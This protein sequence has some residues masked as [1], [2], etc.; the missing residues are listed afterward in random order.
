MRRAV[1]DAY[2]TRHPL[3]LQGKETTPFYVGDTILCRGQPGTISSFASGVYL[4]KEEYASSGGVTISFEVSGEE[5]LVDYTSL[6][7]GKGGA[8]LQRVAPSLRPPPRATPS[9]AYSEELRERVLTTYHAECATSPHA[10]DSKRKRLAPHVYI[11]AQ[12]LIVMSGLQSIY[13]SHLRRFPRD[14]GK[15]SFAGF[16]DMKP[17]YAIFGDRQTCLCKHCENFLCYQDALRVAATFL[18]TMLIADPAA[19]AEE[20]DAAADEPAA[21]PAAA[22]AAVPAAVPAAAPPAAAA[23]AADADADQPTTAAA[24]QPTTTA[25]DDAGKLHLAKLVRVAQLKSKQM[26]VNEFVCGG[27][28]STAKQDC[29][30]GTCNKCGFDRLWGKGLR[31]EVVDAY[32]KLKPGADNVWLTKIKWER[33]KS[34][35]KANTTGQPPKPDEKEMLRERCEGT[36]ID[37]L[38]EFEKHVMPKYPFHRQ[39]LIIQK[40]A[41]QQRDDNLPP[42][43]LDVDSD[44]SENGTIANAREIQSEYWVSKMYSLFISIWS[45]LCSKAWVDRVG[46]LPKGTAVTLEP[47]GASTPGSLKLLPGSVY[48]V[49]EEGSTLEGEATMYHVRERNG[50]LHRVP[51]ERLR[52]RQRRTVAFACVCNEKRHDAAT[53]QHFLNRILAYFHG[54]PTPAPGPPAPAPQPTPY[55]FD[56]SES[57]WGLIHH[58]DN[59]THFKSSKMLHFW[60][61]VKARPPAPPSSSPDFLAA[62][63]AAAESRRANVAAAAARTHACSA[64]KAA[65]A[66][67]AAARTARDDT[68]AHAAATA[69]ATASANVATAATNIATAADA[70][71]D[72]ASDSANATQDAA[73]AAAAALPTK[74]QRLSMLWVEFGCAGHG[75]GP[76]DGLGAVIKQTVRRDIL[77]DNIL[78][79]SGYITSPAEVAEHLHRKFGTN[80]WKVDHMGGKV[81]EVI[82]LYS[83]ATDMHERARVEKS[84]YDT[85]QLA[86][87]TFSYMILDEGVHAR[88]QHSCW[89]PLC[90]GARGRG[91]GTTDSNLICAGCSCEGDAQK[92]WSEQEV[93]RTD[94]LGI[95][96]RR[97]VAQREGHRMGEKIR[98]GMWLAAQDRTKGDTIWICQAVKVPG[99]KADVPCIHT[100]VT[101]RE[102][103]I[104]GTEFGRNDWVIAVNW[105]AKA[106]GDPEERTYEEWQP[107]PA[108]LELYGT[109]TADGAYFLLNSTE[110]RHVNFPMDAAAP[111]PPAP[112]PRKSARRASAQAERPSTAGRRFILPADVENQILALCW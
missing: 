82:V 81:N 11:T 45:Y 48:A 110:L 12:A 111:L 79:S 87:S 97:V 112:A 56:L 32:G 70:T 20:D 52:R 99:A 40:Q 8:R 67:D 1:I 2:D 10:S 34:S 57:F 44:H 5:A 80:E 100:K 92:E 3:N 28:I 13:D 21:A 96:E 54:H 51:R 41:D 63:A 47:E 16:K 88:R 23:D 75:K 64:T 89:N 84:K 33:I 90:F 72:K 35:A 38:D 19:A 62:I 17:W 15:V 49:V 27:C 55:Q 69:A 91:A 14:K 83:D 24:T 98:P 60:S 109:K 101:A 71:A 108:D 42:L 25:D 22:P 59:A 78:T 39:T 105:W 26:F 66:A 107:E 43:V 29:I 86:K 46:A 65:D 77:H 9:F 36:I 104:K 106:A 68:A 50:P 95:A 58:S 103:F 18:A 31:K 94:A 7:K 4:S 76:W 85:L 102:E 6:G 30:M 53:T 37:L 74:Q 73:A 93:Q 61:T